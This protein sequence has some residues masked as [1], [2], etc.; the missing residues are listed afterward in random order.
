MSTKDSSTGKL[1]LTWHHQTSRN[2]WDTRRLRAD[3]CHDGVA[4]IFGEWWGFI[5]SQ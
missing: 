2:R 4:L 5:R 3:D 1:L